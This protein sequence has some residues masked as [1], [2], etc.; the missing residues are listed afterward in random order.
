MK[1]NHNSEEI[2]IRSRLPVI[3]LRDVVVFP[4]MIYPLLV[5]RDFTVKALQEAM[6]LD[7]QVLLIAQRSSSVDNPKSADLYQTGV[8]ARILQVMKMPNGTLKVLVEG[9]VRAEVVS[10]VKTSG[11]LMARLRV[12]SRDQEVP[13]RE[14]PTEPAYP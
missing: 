10:L 9:L 3:P 4:H 1:L 7:K 8:V 12:M 11:Y 6:V 13:D 5:G 2:E 14:A